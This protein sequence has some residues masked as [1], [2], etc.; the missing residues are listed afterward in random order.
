MSDT[1]TAITVT[2][3]ATGKSVSHPLPAPSVSFKPASGQASD[4][5]GLVVATNQQQGTQA[6]QV[7]VVAVSDGTAQAANASD[8]V[9]GV[10]QTSGLPALS[11][12]QGREPYLYAGLGIIIVTLVFLAPLARRRPDWKVRMGL[13]YLAA[14]GLVS[15]ALEGSVQQSVALAGACLLIVFGLTMMR[16]WRWRIAKKPTLHSVPVPNLQADG[17]VRQILPVLTELGFQSEA[18]YEVMKPYGSLAVL[19]LR[20]RKDPV[21]AQVRLST[22]GARRYPHLVFATRLRG[23]E[24]IWTWNIAGALPPQPPQWTSYH[25][26]GMTDAKELYRLHQ[27]H[28]AARPAGSRRGQADRRPDRVGTAIPGRDRLAGSRRGPVQALRQSRLALDDGGLLRLPRRPPREDETADPLTT[29]DRPGSLWTP[30]PVPFPGRSMGWR[31][32][33]PGTGADRRRL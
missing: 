4:Q 31:R 8:A 32:P 13:P 10:G 28:L 26:A 9:T 25:H 15:Y 21:V 33:S 5:A 1:T 7:Q 18:G 6:G 3:P 14:F 20:H 11:H 22:Q 24:Q 12:L 27:Q 16:L 23:G 30:G 29:I 19:S 17:Y 2:D